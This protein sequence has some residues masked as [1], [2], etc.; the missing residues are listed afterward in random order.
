MMA[1]CGC[2]Y[3]RKGKVVSYCKKHGGAVRNGSGKKASR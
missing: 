1:R 3:D 2:G